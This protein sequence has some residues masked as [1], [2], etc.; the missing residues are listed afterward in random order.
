MILLIPL[1]GTSLPTSEKFLVRRL[2]LFVFETLLSLKGYKIADTNVIKNDASQGKD[3][4]LTIALTAPIIFPI[5]DT[6]NYYLHTPDTCA[7]VSDFGLVRTSTSY[8]TFSWSSAEGHTAWEM[9][10]GTEGTPLEKSLRCMT[11][12]LG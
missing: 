3:I 8:A 4:Y 10:Y 12:D 11:T 5:I 2:D 6:T 1:C 9:A 7:N